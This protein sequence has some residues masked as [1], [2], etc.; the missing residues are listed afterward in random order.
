VIELI[1][2]LAGLAISYLSK[3]SLWECLFQAI[4]LGSAIA[5]IFSLYS[6]LLLNKIDRVI[7]AT[8]LLAT[9]FPALYKRKKLFIKLNLE[10]LALLSLT[11]ALVFIC[12]SLPFMLKMWFLGKRD[13]LNHLM[14]LNS[15]FSTG[16]Y[17]GLYAAYP[18]GLHSLAYL[19]GLPP[20]EAISRVTVLFYTFMFLSVYY[21]VYSKSGS[22]YLSCLTTVFTAVSPLLFKMIVNDYWSLIAGFTLLN[23]FLAEW[24]F[25]VPSIIYASALILVYP[26]L[27]LWAL[28]TSIALAAWNKNLKPLF[29]LFTAALI[30]APWWVKQLK[31]WQAYIPQAYRE[32]KM[33]KPGFPHPY[34]IALAIAALLALIIAR[35]ELVK[36]ASTLLTPLIVLLPTLYYLESY[37]WYY[38]F[39]IYLWLPLTIL[40]S[41]AVWESLSRKAVVKVVGLTLA[42]TVF[43][44]SIL[45]LTPMYKEKSS[46]SLY[47]YE[48]ELSVNKSQVFYLA[49]WFSSNCPGKAAA[50][51][52]MPD[53]K[54][55]AEW[56]SQERG[57]SV[58]TPRKPWIP[59]SDASLKA[60]DYVISLEWMNYRVRGFNKIY[61]DTFLVVWAKTKS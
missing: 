36:L 52:S 39:H 48:Y 4:V 41:K 54:A 5:I 32:F 57:R 53:L 40:A 46:P 44:L 3:E 14:M 59:L 26:H 55:V 43:S 17:G 29:S 23:F 18:L 1:L 49:K 19:T 11:I 27:A 16:R 37:H 60:R 42:L 34:A 6:T 35:D 30:S 58:F 33:V 10:D 56:V 20:V 24:S 13:A 7:V 51:G 28:I 47:L 12:H 21:L 38:R 2:F 22:H 31:A 25:N 15:I 8:A 9:A 50:Q 45:A 61:S